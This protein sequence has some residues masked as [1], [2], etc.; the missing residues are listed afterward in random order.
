[1][2]AASVH[3]SASLRLCAGK[4]ML[5]KLLAKHVLKDDENGFIRIDMSE[6]QTKHELSKLIG[7]PP[8]RQPG[9]TC[10]RSAPLRL[11]RIACLISRVL[12]V[13]RCSFVFASPSPLVCSFYFY[14]FPLL[15]LLPTLFDSLQGYVGHEEGGQLTT[16]LA[17]CPNAV[18]LFD[19]VSI[20]AAAISMDLGVEH[21]AGQRDST[22]RHA[23]VG[24]VCS[25]ARFA[26]PLFAACAD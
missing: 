20:S 1:M 8:V 2:T 13:L 17:K 26:L 6:Y 11:S 22:H 3:F 16:K 25:S 5:A 19:E 9:D 23:P 18:V 4:T 12:V 21:G 14:F 7:S 24:R 15:F 10:A